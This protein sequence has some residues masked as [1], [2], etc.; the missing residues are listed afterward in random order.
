MCNI[1]LKFT[2]ILLLSE[3]HRRPRSETHRR[4]TCLI[5]D[6]LETLIWFIGDQHSW[7]ENHRRPTCLIGDLDM[8]HQ[9]LTGMSVSNWSP[10]GHA[11]FQ[12]V[13]DGVSDGSPMNHILV[14][15]V[16]SNR[17]VSLRWGMSVT[18]GGCQ[19]S[20]GLQSGISVSYVACRG[21]WWV[22][23]QACWSPIK[24]VEVFDG[25]PLS[26]QACRSPI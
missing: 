24:H 4:P 18:D 26:N 6:P 10:I 1:N 14:S 12:M 7:S 22:S 8:L 20:M 3:T 17:H 16:S 2:K 11:R 25:S 21:L 23:N 13:S 19:S 15:N 9:R 5:G